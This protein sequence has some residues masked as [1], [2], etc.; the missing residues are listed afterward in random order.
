[1]SHIVSTE[2]VENEEIL[3]KWLEGKKNNLSVGFS[4]E[5]ENEY[6]SN[7]ELWGGGEMRGAERSLNIYDV[8]GSVPGGRMMA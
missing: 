3:G 4:R 6:T 5:R 1:M 2:N 8:P 7:V